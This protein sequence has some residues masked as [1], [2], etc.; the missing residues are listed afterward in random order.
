MRY[1]YPGLIEFELNIVENDP[2]RLYFKVY[3]QDASITNKTPEF[4]FKASNGIR[5]ISRGKVE[6]AGDIVFLRGRT[7]CEDNT[8]SSYT[9]ESPEKCLIGHDSILSAFAE[10][11]EKRGIPVINGQRLQEQ[12]SLWD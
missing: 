7:R 5:L 6:L 4:S 8:P 9:Y 11:A 3:E 2:R 10:L 12:L 1:N